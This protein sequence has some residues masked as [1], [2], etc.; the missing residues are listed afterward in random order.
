MAVYSVTFCPCST[1]LVSISVFPNKS[2]VTAS[3]FYKLYFTVLNR[4]W[5]IDK[6]IPLYCH[7][8]NTKPDFD[9]AFLYLEM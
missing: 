7:K 6:F 8:Q 9:I 3:I 4:S 5:N 2:D 1:Q